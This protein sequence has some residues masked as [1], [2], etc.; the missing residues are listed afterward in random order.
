M[1]DGDVRD[2]S[3]EVADGRRIAW[4]E[5]GEG[6]PLLRLPG[7]PGSRW[8]IRADRTPWDERG[9]RVITTERPGYGASTRLPGRRFAEHAHDLAALLDH[10]G[11]DAAYVMGGSGGAPH[12][13]A[14]AA[15]HPGRVRAATVV[16]GAAPL[17]ES[18]ID[19]MIDLNVRGQRLV[20][21]GDV[22]G[23]RELLA[24]LREALLA[25]PLAGMRGIMAEAPDEDQQIMN[26][27]LW[28]AAF[29]RAVRESL[30]QGL[31]GWVDES[32]VIA[33][34]WSGFELADVRTSLTWWHGAEDRNVPLSAARR[35]VDKL[36]NATLKVWARAGH[37]TPY[38]LEGEILDE[39]LSRG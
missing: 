22:E 24:P 5:Y 6:A 1:S 7:T 23:L 35:L 19:Q 8:T 32:M 27:P 13:L 36:P 26:D 12:V 20:S 38:R 9:L 21:A 3:M 25:D 11:I 37:L 28:Q 30:A 33:S 29:V 16:V 10:L 14:F 34:P 15:L 17:E 39:L 4:T 2:H 18:E 31:D